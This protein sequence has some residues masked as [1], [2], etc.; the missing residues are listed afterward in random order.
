MTGDIE[1]IVDAPHDP[2]ES[3]EIAIRT[4]AG[5]VVLPLEVFGVVG[6]FEALRI[7]VDRADHTGPRSRDHEDTAF[8]FF[9][10]K[11][12]LVD[13]GCHDSG[14][15]QRARAGFERRCPRQRRNHM[16]AGLSLPPGIDDRTAA[17]AYD[18]V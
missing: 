18:R 7:A 12:S 11:S 14:Q 16:T 15:W 17:A 3:V 1:H 6:L 5:E 13:D 10:G 9:D 8:A 4:I 2:E